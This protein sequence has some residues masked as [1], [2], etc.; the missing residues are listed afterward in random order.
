LKQLDKRY[1]T[2]Y[3]MSMIENL[4]KAVSD[5]IAFFKKNL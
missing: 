4:E 5:Q 1:K 3:G 2:K